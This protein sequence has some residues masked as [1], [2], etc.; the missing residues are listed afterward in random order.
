MNRTSTT[1]RTESRGYT[2]NR[3]PRD[4]YQDV[5]DRIIAALEAGTPPWR[6]PWDPD[7]SGAICPLFYPRAFR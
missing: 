1:S 2:A 6:K 3:A 4:H 5:T 7:G